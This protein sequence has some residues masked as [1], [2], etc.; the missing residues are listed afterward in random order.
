MELT[1]GQWLDAPG[2]ALV[3]LVVT[4]FDWCWRRGFLESV[5]RVI[6]HKD[7][8]MRCQHKCNAGV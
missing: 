1:Q 6:Y 8:S 3:L 5:L 7:I 4:G 2:L